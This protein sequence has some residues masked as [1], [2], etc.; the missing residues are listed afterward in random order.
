MIRPW[1]SKGKDIGCPT[2][3]KCCRNMILLGRH[4]LGN[5][6]WYMLVQR[7]YSAATHTTTANAYEQSKR[8]WE[9]VGRVRCAY[10]VSFALQGGNRILHWLSCTYFWCFLFF[11]LFFFAFS[12]KNTW[13]LNP[14][15]YAKKGFSPER[16]A[17]NAYYRIPALYGKNKQKIENK[18]KTEKQCAEFLVAV[19]EPS[20]YMLDHFT[21]LGRARKS[22]LNERKR[23]PPCNRISRHGVSEN[24]PALDSWCWQWWEAYYQMTKN[25]FLSN[26]TP[27][28]LRDLQRN[29]KTR[30]SYVNHRWEPTSKKTNQS[31]STTS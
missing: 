9:H 10:F 14:V 1:W 19:C 3:L 15:E 28:N 4:C 26:R 22:L 24:H 23:I 31:Q 8:R 7:A 18:K 6:V 12:P 16:D 5:P 20:E 25:H 29:K 21:S 13:N 2:R 30:V 17:K 27:D 11:F